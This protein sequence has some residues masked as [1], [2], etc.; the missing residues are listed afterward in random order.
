[1]LLLGSAL[2]YFWPKPPQTLAVEM[3]VSLGPELTPWF[4]SPKT[5]Q[6][7]PSRFQIQLD[8]QSDFR[9]ANPDFARQVQLGY[10]FMGRNRV[11]FEGIVPCRLDATKRNSEL[12]LPNPHRVNPQSI[13]LFIA[14]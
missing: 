5:I 4:T 12:T 2:W 8:L 3:P 6:A 7:D 10:S 14:R 11:L 9:Q 1:M 13:H